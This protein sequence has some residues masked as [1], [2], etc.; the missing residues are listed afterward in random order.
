MSS[1]NLGKEAMTLLASSTS[2]EGVQTI[3]LPRQ[4]KTIDIATHKDSMTGQ[5]VVLWSD[6]TIVFRDALYLQ[7]GTKAIPFLKGA[8][9]KPL[10]PLRIALIPGAT[11]DV[12]VDDDSDDDDVLFSRLSISTPNVT[13]QKK[14][15]KPPAQKQASQQT[16]PTTRHVTPQ[17]AQTA[18]H[19][20]PQ[21]MLQEPTYASY[22]SS[23]EPRSI[24]FFGSFFSK[25]TPE[26]PQHQ[27]DPHVATTT[28]MNE[29]VTAVINTP[30]KD[31][32]PNAVDPYA[33]RNPQYGLV[34][35]AMDN[36]S[37]ME[38]PEGTFESL[39]GKPKDGARN[40]QCD[41]SVD[42]ILKYTD[43]VQSSDAAKHSARSPQAYSTTTT[44]S[45]DITETT[46]KASK[47]NVEAQVAL[48]D[49]Y[50]EGSGVNKDLQAALDW[51]T[52]A[53][54][55]EDPVAQFKIGTL[56]DNGEG[57]SRD[58]SKAEEWYL[59]AAKQGYSPA[60][61]SLG[62]LYELGQGRLAEK[63]R[64][65]K[66]AMEW[67]L[68]ASN[69]GDAQAQYEIGRMFD[70][71]VGVTQDNLKAKQWYLQAAEN[72][73]LGAKLRLQSL[74]AHV[75]TGTSR[76]VNALQGMLNKLALP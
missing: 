14:K 60:Q 21:S 28:D 42:N 4:G 47:G 34:E 38:V 31:L 6:I 43:G 25:A 1:D 17:V 10:D 74:S 7:Y 39:T 22:K 63:D 52:K 29:S 30:G 72:G 44:T 12:V 54:D 53:A 48:G 50:R 58:H 76:V 45:I 66:V 13:V 20:A 70:H 3:R 8:D 46:A 69:Q 32:Q 71:G 24:S 55:Q 2:R 33:L 15:R 56:Y 27:S 26:L 51:F 5:E 73:H 41:S 68:Q 40:P 37:H 64:D 59:R 16:P 65:Y 35:A 67:Y 61:R 62:S 19:R 11:L 49:M 18:H 9:L 75:G 36:Y 57:V 23:G